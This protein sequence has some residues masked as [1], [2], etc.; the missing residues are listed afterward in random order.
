VSLS[1]CPLQ[2]FGADRWDDLVDRFDEAWLWHRS[3]FRESADF[4]FEQAD[5][6]F[7]VLDGAARPVAIVPL[8]LTHYRA[9]RIV[10][11][12]TLRSTGGPATAN[13][14]GAK[15][16]G[17][18]LAFVR[19]HLLALANQLGAM[20]IDMSCPPMAP[21]LRGERCPRTNPLAWIGCSGSM[22]QTWVVDLRG[23]E[24]AIRKAYSSGTREELRKLTREPFDVRG[25]PQDGDAQTFYELLTATFGR[26]GM[27]PHPRAYTQYVF[28][29]FVQRGLARVLFLV[30]EGAVVAGNITATYKGGAQYW[31]GA[32][33][34]A[35]MSGANRALVD[36]QIMEAKAGGSEFFEAGQAGL[37]DDDQVLRG[38]SD[39]KRSFG[40]ALYPL[41]QGSIVV[42]PRM[43]AAL[44][45]VRSFRAGR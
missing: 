36:R 25:G 44:Q 14:L 32:S 33:R 19:E 45:L 24:D 2:E 35:G 4:R 30:R 40:S 23:S 41:F 31:F 20:D 10:P 39:F 42:R 3:D 29:R 38:I 8:R 12:R 27:L 22:A 5:H 9:S 7:V 16:R 21:A 1:A 6:S 18:V 34:D 11:V 26:R 17:K 37:W 43:Y 15:H 28:D 13:E